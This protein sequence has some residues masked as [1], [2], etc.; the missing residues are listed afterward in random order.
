MYKI[1][2]LKMSREVLGSLLDQLIKEKLSH[3][4]GRCQQE[5]KD[6]TLLDGDK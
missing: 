2:L 1:L 3:L 5:E 6:L 4:E